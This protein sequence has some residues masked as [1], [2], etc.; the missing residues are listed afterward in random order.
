MCGCCRTLRAGNNGVVDYIHM[1]FGAARLTTSAVIPIEDEKLPSSTERAHK[2]DAPT[3]SQRQ[4]KTAR[5]R[6]P[7][8]AR[9]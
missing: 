7:I 5:R 6:Y 8:T 1:L 3:M 2:T 9:G 4:A